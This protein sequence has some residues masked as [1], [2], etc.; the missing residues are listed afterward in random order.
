MQ[1]QSCKPACA[2]ALLAGGPLARVTP[3]ARLRLAAAALLRRV[4]LEGPAAAL[5]AAGGLRSA[6]EAAL[7]ALGVRARSAA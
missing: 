2:P 7:A 5:G 1:P 6:G 4:G 3:A